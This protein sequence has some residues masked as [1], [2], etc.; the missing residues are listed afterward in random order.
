LTSIEARVE[1]VH[2]MSGPVLDLR[3]VEILSSLD[4][5]ALPAAVED[6]DDEAGV[7]P[8]LTGPGDGT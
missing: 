4:E 8:A 5:L 2:T 1:S 6:E 7:L 3:A